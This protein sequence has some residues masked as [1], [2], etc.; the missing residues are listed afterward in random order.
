VDGVVKG[1]VSL[2]VEESVTTDWSIVE[3]LVVKS[4]VEAE[5]SVKG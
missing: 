4:P 1:S 2:T 5:T 3:S